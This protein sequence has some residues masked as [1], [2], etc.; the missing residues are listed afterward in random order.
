MKQMSIMEKSFYLTS[1]FTDIKTQSWSSSDIK[2]ALLIIKK[3]NEHKVYLPDLSEVEDLDQEVNKR[4]KEIPKEMF[5]SRSEL[6]SILDIKSNHLA[7]ETNK[8][9]RSMHNRSIIN[10]YDLIYDKNTKGIGGVSWFEYF[11][12]NV[13]G[14]V[15]IKFTETSLKILLL[16]IRYVRIDLKT[17]L[18]LNNSYSILSFIFFK[19]L[20]DASKKIEE[21][22]DINEFKEKMGLK[23]KYS[24]INLFR[25]R[26][27][28]V[29]KKEVNNNT[30]I[31]LKYDLIKEGRS[32]KKIKFSFNY[33][34]SYK[35]DSTEP[36]KSL[37]DFD[38]TNIKS[39]FE[40][41][42]KGWGIGRNK[43]KEIEDKYSLNTITNAIKVT[44]D[45]IEKDSIK[46]SPASFFLGTL[47]NKQLQEEVAF[48]QVQGNLR[49]EQE[50]K[51]MEALASE[52]DSIQKFINDHSDEISN[53][54]SIKSGGGSFELSLN[55]SDEL[56]NIACIDI[57]K[58]KDFRPKFA[59]LD[60][61]FFDMKEKR[62][63]RPNMYIFLTLIKK[64]LNTG[65]I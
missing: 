35:K 64:Y 12:H 9:V 39:P 61:G 22:I 49:K 51:E 20:K 6:I 46:K 44:K 2:I 29:I 65:N 47:E 13:N 58:F 37:I 19:T 42:F 8:I 10:A 17:I 45:A 4:I 40:Q 5:I 57:K 48:E 55:I 11:K 53:Y 54:L 43:I 28:D 7:R 26:V 30:E 33:K 56:A 31:D 3:L 38:F 25:V 16:M 63:V 50:K 52:Y 34:D 15:D 18:S 59:V 41:I 60:Q 62:E 24:E 36:D 1:L 27:L 32:F 23:G 14:G 21:V